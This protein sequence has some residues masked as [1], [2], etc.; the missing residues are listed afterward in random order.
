MKDKRMP[1]LMGLQVLLVILV[2]VNLL[3]TVELARGPQPQETNRR[4]LPCESIPWDFVSGYPECA[5]HLMHAMNVTN[6]HIQRF[7]GTLPGSDIQNAPIVRAWRAARARV[8][9]ATHT[10][11]R[12]GSSNG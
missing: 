4:S 12:E 11:Q 7:N 6:V 1:W 2:A 5:D 8:D 3:M 10:K 9:N